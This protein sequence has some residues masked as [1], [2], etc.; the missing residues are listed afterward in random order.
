MRN[1]RVL[2]LLA[3]LGWCCRAQAA[4]DCNMPEFEFV[5]DAY[6]CLSGTFKAQN[7]Q[8]Q[9]ME[10]KLKRPSEKIRNELAQV[11]KK[12]A[13][14]TGD[15]PK[16]SAARKRLEKWAYELRRRVDEADRDAREKRDFIGQIKNEG[17]EC[18]TEKC[19]KE[20]YAKTLAGLIGF[21]RQPACTLPQIAD[22]CEVYV[23][24]TPPQ[25]KKSMAPLLSEKLY[26]YREKVRIN[27]P[28]KCVYLFLASGYP[29]VWDI[30]TTEGTDLR[31]IYVGGDLPQL[32]RGYPEGTEV[33]V[34]YRGEL[35]KGAENC[36][37]SSVDLDKRQENNFLDRLKIAP[38]RRIYVSD[39]KIGD[40]AP[41]DTYRYRA[42]NAAGA[43]AAA[44][45][46][47]REDGWKKLVADGKV[48]KVTSADIE[49]FKKNGVIN[50]DNGKFVWRRSDYDEFFRYEDD[51]LRNGYILLDDVEKLPAG[52]PHVFVFVG[53]GQRQP[54]N[55]AL[56]ATFGDTVSKVGMFSRSF[57]ML[58]A[59][60]EDLPEPADCN[61]PE[62]IVQK[63]LCTDV[64]LRQKN[65]RLRELL[66]QRRDEMPE[67]IN[68]YQV[69][70]LF[71][72]NDCRTGAC[73]EKVLDD[74]VSWLENRKYLEQTETARPSLCRL[75]DIKPDCEVYAYSA[76]QTGNEMKGVYISEENETFN[77]KVKINQPGKCVILFLSAYEPVVW[78]IYATPATDLQAVV[79]GGHEEQM[80]RGMNPK[81]QTKVRDGN[82]RAA[83]DDVCLGSYY[84]KDEIVEAVRNLNLGVKNVRL[85]D[86]PVIGE[87]VDDKFYEY[88]PQVIDGE[89]VM[90][91]IAPANTGL[92]QLT[93]E[94]KLRKAGKDDIAK[95]KAAG[96]SFLT[97]VSLKGDRNPFEY[98]ALRMYVLLKE[99][100]RLPRGLAGSDGIVLMVPKD[101][102]VPDNNDGHNDFYRVD[103][104]ASEFWAD[105]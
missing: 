101:M 59:E 66:E 33:R 50:L 79:A 8:I 48:R 89:F 12:L 9:D 80:L 69:Y 14:E 54:E 31:G 83:G 20:V 29:Q 97:G 81:V 43:T 90:P 93:K 57:L 104:P 36:L 7:N 87:E 42:E 98:G 32:V 18:R 67:M 38:E 21:S 73:A 77:A 4:V 53:A 23:Y 15:T 96:Y 71:H 55:L 24:N 61:R 22:E 2:A 41:L 84:G 13:R 26:T 49:R 46:P 27:R 88:N 5:N 86:K 72:L 95:I 45:L 37:R 56:D 47:P 1:L 19:M 65:L 35:L 39:G 63:V 28:D 17:R 74:A 52:D 68:A 103:L 82:H 34:H 40:N 51:I 64:S 92:E 94:G 75:K 102:R 11:K 99:V 76:Y 3:G 91:E 100:V 16:A 44:V 25:A 62:G 6:V 85:L 105:K 10:D 58:P 60:R 30:L 78:D 70:T